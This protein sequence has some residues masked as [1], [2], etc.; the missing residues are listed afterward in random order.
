[1]R[2]AKQ[3]VPR[4]SDDVK[5]QSLSARKSAEI[6]GEF[7]YQHTL[8]VREYGIVSSVAMLVGQWSDT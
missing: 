4:V 8:S 1:M 6:L 7:H 2:G 5:S 3:S